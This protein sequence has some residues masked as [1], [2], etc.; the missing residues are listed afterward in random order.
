M[1]N[2]EVLLVASAP[3]GPW[4][5]YFI[6]GGLLMLLFGLG[7]IAAGWRSPALTGGLGGVFVAF[8]GC[9]VLLVGMGMTEHRAAAEAVLD[10]VGSVPTEAIVIGGLVA[11]FVLAAITR[12]R[13]R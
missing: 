13:G 3:T 2:S 12:S 4:A 11:G 5:I 8:T 7:S 6:L 9:C 1:P 10:R